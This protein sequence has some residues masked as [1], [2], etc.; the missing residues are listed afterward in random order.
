MRNFSAS[1]VYD[2]EAYVFLMPFTYFLKNLLD[3]WNSLPQTISFL[4][5][6]QNGRMWE[7]YMSSDEAKGLLC[8]ESCSY[9]CQPDAPMERHKKDLRATVVPS[10]LVVPPGIQRFTVSGIRGRLDWAYSWRM[11]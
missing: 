4:D 5:G 10:P 2:L 1:Q 3:M 9:N 7:Y 11:E 8:P 6:F